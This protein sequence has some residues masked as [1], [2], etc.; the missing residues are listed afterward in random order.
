[1]HKTKHLFFLLVLLTA[2]A[3][4]R[5][6]SAF[7]EENKV[8]YLFTPDPTDVNKTYKEWRRSF[9]EE[10]GT[11]R[12]DRKLFRKT[13]FQFPSSSQFRQTI[14]FS[15]EGTGTTG[16]LLISKQLRNGAVAQYSGTWEFTES[17][18]TL[19]LRYVDTEL[20]QTVTESY[21]VITLVQ[22]LLLLQVR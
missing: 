19:T 8:R 14:A 2:F 13:N 11:G 15:S 16:K 9:E 7:E 20:K 17:S 10:A 3:G 1:M 21:E 5:G 22:D 18:Q 12:T 4:C 6:R